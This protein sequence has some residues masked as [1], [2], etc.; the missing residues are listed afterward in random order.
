MSCERPYLIDAVPIRRSNTCTV[1]LYWSVTLCLVSVYCS[2]SVIVK[3]A[4][5]HFVTKRPL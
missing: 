4:S 1:M 5:K 3:L 2:V